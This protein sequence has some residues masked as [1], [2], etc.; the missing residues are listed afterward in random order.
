MLDDANLAGHRLRNGRSA[1]GYARIGDMKNLK[2]TYSN[3]QYK[4]LFHVVLISFVL[5]ICGVTPNAWADSGWDARIKEFGAFSPV[6]AAGGKGFWPGDANGIFYAGD[7]VGMNCQW[8]YDKIGSKKTRPSW[9]LSFAVDG[10]VHKTKQI[11]SSPYDSMA[12]NYGSEFDTWTT[13]QAGKH[14]IECRLSFGDATPSDNFTTTT[15]TVIPKKPEKSG[16]FPV[17][18][19]NFSSPHS[20][21]I[22]NRHTAVTVP[23]V[24]TVQSSPFGGA[25]SLGEYAKQMQN[26][27]YRVYC[28]P[29]L[30][31][32]GS[33]QLGGFEK[34]IAKRKVLLAGPQCSVNFSINKNGSYAVRA[35][36]LQMR[37]EGKPPASSPNNRVAFQV[38]DAPKIGNQAPAGVIHLPSKMTPPARTTVPVRGVTPPSPHR[39]T[40]P[41]PSRN[42]AP[43]AAR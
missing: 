28:V 30:V 43:P 8:E 7:S 34:V 39:T 17:K 32:T 24:L 42:V 22:F 16:L 9:T 27:P 23:V 13:S 35:Q 15:V 41:A 11:K 26:T 31:R 4:I 21:Q 1:P 20:K 19:P 14:T 38:V 3:L 6:P 5:G 25:S 37:G 36:L 33:G 40:P 18:A 10:H 29:E 12:L 2:I